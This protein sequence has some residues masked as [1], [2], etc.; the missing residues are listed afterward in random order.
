MAA[1]ASSVQHLFAAL[2]I[3]RSGKCLVNCVVD[4]TCPLR[5]GLLVQLLATMQDLSGSPASAFVE[6]GGVGIVLLESQQILEAGFLERVAD[7][8]AS[9]SARAH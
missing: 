3:T 2:L 1:M 4:P 7:K 5:T 6:L 9:L 8:K